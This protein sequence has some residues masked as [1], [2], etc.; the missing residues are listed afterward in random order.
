[1]NKEITRKHVLTSFVWKFMEHGGTQI[2]QFFVQI[3]LARLLLPEQY[4]LIALVMI[5]ITIANVFIQNGFNTALVQKKE[6]D[7]LDYSSVFC[8]SFVVAILCY[9]LMFVSAPFIAEFY[10]EMK[11][12]NI[13]RVLSLTMIFGSVYS[14]QIAYINR[15]MLFR[16]LFFVSLTGIIL[17]GIAGITTAYMGFGVWALV[18]QQFVS[19]IVSVIF[20][21]FAIEWKPR[22]NY[23]HKRVIELFS[24]GWKLLVSALLNQIYHELRTLIIGKVYSTSMLGYYTR[25]T[26]FPTFIVLNIDGSVQAVMLPTLSANQDDLVK[27]KRMVKRTITMSAFIIFPTLVGLAVVADPLVKILLTEKWLGSVPFL[28]IA[29]GVY[30]LIPLQN[31]NLQVIK[32]LGRS[33]IFLKLE[34]I[35]KVIG[36]GLMIASIPFG[37]YALAFS[38]VIVSVIS[39]YINA[40]PNEELIEYGFLKQWKDIF[41]T[42]VLAIIMG[43]IA[44]SFHNLDV[45][46]VL[47]ILIQITSGVSTYFGLAFLIKHESLV[48]I[49][50]NIR[51]RKND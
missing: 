23:S 3:V 14:I 40:H 45:S 48:Y 44:Y 28:Q 13:I 15:N 11:L 42:F 31:M 27:I 35:K 30:L 5:L 41:P 26:Q 51:R 29:C 24:Y 34:I 50:D 10:N 37:I 25:G 47:L 17:S 38:A 20:L 22:F 6:V 49:I 9:I 33:D 36:L 2:I 12:V 19:R 32:A 16:R 21:L 18:I 1:M 46:P 43:I 4:G 8:V 7:N 39:N